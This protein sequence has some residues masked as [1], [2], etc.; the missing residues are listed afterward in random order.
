MRKWLINCLVETEGLLKDV[1]T[2]SHVHCK[3]NNISEPV[4]D[5]VVTADHQDEVIYGLLN[6]GNS[7]D[8]E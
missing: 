4:R 3:C 6:S 1:S 8:L 5:R 2:H 7:Y